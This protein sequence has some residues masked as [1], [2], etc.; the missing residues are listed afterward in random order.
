ME[1]K[2]IIDNNL[3]KLA[4]RLSKKTYDKISENKRPKLISNS[5]FYISDFKNDIIT[6]FID[7]SIVKDDTIL[8]LHQSAKDLY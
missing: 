7:N 8:Y 4:G 3:E 6:V 1:L 2:I 5:Y